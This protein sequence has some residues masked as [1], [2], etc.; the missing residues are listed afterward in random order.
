[1]SFVEYKEEEY[2]EAAILWRKAHPD[3]KRIKKKEVVL[4]SSG[5]NIPLGNRM[6]YMR[7]HPN[8]LTEK[9]LAFW[10]SYGISQ[11]KCHV[12]LSKEEY[13]EA[14]YIWRQQNKEALRIPVK[15][16][17]TISNGKEVPL[18]PHFQYL[19]NHADSLSSQEKDFWSSYGLLLEK[20]KCVRCTEE[21]YQEA[22]RIWRRENPE[23]KKIPSM[24]EVTISSGKTIPLGARL[25]DLRFFE[26][27]LT[28]QQ[29][30]FWA[31]YGLY[32]PK[33]GEKIQEKEY[34]EAAILW[35]KNH[36]NR[37]K[38]SVRERVELDSGKQVP[39]GFR[40]KNLALGIL[41]LSEEEK[42]FWIQL[43]LLPKTPLSSEE[44][45]REAAILFRKENPKAKAVPT[46]T[47]V[48]IA[49]GKKI[50]LGKRVEYMKHHPNF[51][52]EDQKE[53]WASFSVLNKE[54]PTTEKE[55]R[56]AAILWRKTHPEEK[57]I[58]R[59]EVV[60]LEN[61]RTIHLGTRMATM[62]DHT[63]FL[64]EEQKE[65][66]KEYGLFIERQ[67]R[68][69]YNEEEFRE[70]AILWKKENP[71]RKRIVASDK[72]QIS[73][74]KVVPLGKHLLRL[75][76]RKETLTR[77]EKEFWDSYG[78]NYLTM[79]E[80]L[81]EFPPS[82]SEDSFLDAA[83]SYLESEIKEGFSYDKVFEKL[84]GSSLDEGKKELLKKKFEQYLTMKKQ[85][86]T[87]NKDDESSR[88]Q[89]TL[90]EKASLS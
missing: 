53:F 78:L 9:Q 82:E 71:E 70:A 64:S 59:Y 16:K 87:K 72:I 5:R 45:Y 32:A 69:Y 43:R 46:K 89:K 8:L 4:I 60:T 90:H 65:F 51:L 7:S 39:L 14:A 15:T 79:K 42:K 36:P 75:R 63:A 44:E 84:F 76:K 18:G 24:T 55:Y 21:E 2:Q 37:Q 77:E 23:E 30:E 47:V 28:P 67:N 17:I 81:A 29:K 74:G 40:I 52:S 41:P 56:E 11:E 68:T 80:R 85:L 88:M 33:P 48:K 61:G 1:M 27:T 73:N 62:R 83:F 50:S 12:F 19:R 58:P 25:C 86:E 10:S 49:S 66:W 26:S 35:R 38:I 31:S 6:Q 22:A 13:K 3:E 57:T 54:P 34:K 20:N